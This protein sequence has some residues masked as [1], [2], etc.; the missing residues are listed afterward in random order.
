MQDSGRVFGEL[1]LKAGDVFL[2]IGCGVGEYAMHAAELVGSSGAVYALDKSP[3]LIRGL[4]EW[5]TKKGAANVTAM[6]AD[7]TGPLPIRDGAIDVCLVATVLHVPEMTRSADRLFSEIRRVLK[8]GG[9]AAIVECSKN[10]LSYGPPEQMR[11]S[12]DQ[13]DAMAARSGFRKVSLLDLGFNYMIRFVP[14]ET[15]DGE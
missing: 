3:D 8:P 15:K 7:A 4:T 10:D 6:V 1:G 9:C 5:A 11:L 14:A 2:D 12:P 13:V